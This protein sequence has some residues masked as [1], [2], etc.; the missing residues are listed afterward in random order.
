MWITCGEFVRNSNSYAQNIG[1]TD[2]FYIE[3]I[4]QYLHHGL[5]TR[6][7]RCNEFLKRNQRIL[8][9]FAAPGKKELPQSRVD[10]LASAKPRAGDREGRTRLLPPMSN[11]KPAKVSM[12]RDGPFA[13]RPF[14]LVGTGRLRWGGGPFYRLRPGLVRSSWAGGLGCLQSG[15]LVGG[16]LD[17]P[18]RVGGG[19][20]SVRHRPKG[21]SEREAFVFGG[22]LKGGSATISPGIEPPPPSEG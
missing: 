3:I 15:T 19:L 22:S 16:I 6:R 4:I 20:A 8:R 10:A 7:R 5:C 18:D 9:D 11:R 13:E 14:S 2:L 1:F 17:F 21:S 12:R